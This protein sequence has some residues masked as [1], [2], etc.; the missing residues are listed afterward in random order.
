MT[1]T[2]YFRRSPPLIQCWPG[3]P[4]LSWPAGMPNLSSTVTYAPG[5]S[6]PSYARILPR[7]VVR[8]LG[9][10]SFANLVVLP[11][12]TLTAFVPLLVPP[13]TTRYVPAGSFALIESE[14]RCVA[15]LRWRVVFVLVLNA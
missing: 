10:V 8:F 5:R 14:P 13:T 6:A 15:V 3:A 1:L 11:F 12:L 7:T 4:D 2:V 9:T